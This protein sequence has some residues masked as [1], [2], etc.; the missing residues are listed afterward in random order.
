[1]LNTYMPNECSVTMPGNTN[2]VKNLNIYGKDDRFF[3]KNMHKRY[4]IRFACKPDPFVN[5]LLENGVAQILK[6]HDGPDQ[7]ILLSPNQLP[8]S[9]EYYKFYCFA[10]QRQVVE[11]AMQFVMNFVKPDKKSMVCFHD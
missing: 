1:M 6:I 8:E 11:M 4:G 5:A 9:Y 3:I 2:Y 10:Y 7:Y